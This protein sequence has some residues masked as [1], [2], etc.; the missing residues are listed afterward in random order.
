MVCIKSQFGLTFGLKI[1][2]RFPQN[3]ICTIDFQVTRTLKLSLN[4]FRATFLTLTLFQL[5][6]LHL[7]II[8][9][10]FK[11]VSSFCPEGRSVCSSRPWQLVSVRPQEF[12]KLT[13]T[14]QKCQGIAMGNEIV[15][16]HKLFSGNKLRI[17]VP[18]L[19]FAKDSLML[20][21]QHQVGFPEH[22]WSAVTYYTGLNSCGT[23]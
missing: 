6:D 10:I 18:V 13:H 7:N 8:K 20:Q 23:N 2:A 4:Y 3:P 21:S 14:R 19:G 11:S 12:T 9:T 5:S 16:V 15:T 1:W 22:G 17:A